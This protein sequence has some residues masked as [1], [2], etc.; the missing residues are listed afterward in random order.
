MS[1]A[2][3]IVEFINTTGLNLFVSELATVIVPAR[4]SKNK[5]LQK[6]FIKKYG[7]VNKP[8]MFQTDLGLFVHPIIFARLSMPASQDEK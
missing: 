7:M 5:R 4:K 6:K 3:E 8:G 2:K 1:I